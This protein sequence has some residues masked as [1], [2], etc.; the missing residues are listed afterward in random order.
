MT[1]ENNDNYFDDK[2]NN[3][4]TDKWTEQTN[5]A[6]SSD[7]LGNDR[8]ILGQKKKLCPNYF[9]GKCYGTLRI[10]PRHPFQVGIGI[11]IN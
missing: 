10:L 8:E 7:N 2:K 6:L 3:E 9:M 5:D 4:K 11:Q 1:T